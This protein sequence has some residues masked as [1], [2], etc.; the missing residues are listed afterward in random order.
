MTFYSIHFIQDTYNNHHMQDTDCSTTT[1]ELVGFFKLRY[2]KLAFAIY[3]MR[4]PGLVWAGSALWIGKT[5]T[6]TKSQT[7]L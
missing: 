4:S 2:V 1:K 5:S 7:P 6:F 3:N